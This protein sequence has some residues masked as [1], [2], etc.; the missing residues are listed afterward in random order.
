MNTPPLL[1]AVLPS[2]ASATSTAFSQERTDA[3]VT[4][5]PFLWLEEMEGPGALAWARGENEKTL[6]VLQSDP[7]YRPFYEQALFILQAKDRIADVPS[8]GGGLEQF[9]RDE[10]QVR[11]VWRRTTRE[12]DRSQHPKWETILDVDAL[13]AAENRNWVFQ[14]HS[15]LPP[16]GRRC[17][18]SLS[19]GGKDAVSI[20]E[21]DR[22]AK[23]FVADGFH[24][25]EGKQDVSWV[26]GDTL[27]VAR[28]WGEGTLTQAGYAFVVK[29]LKRAQPLSEAREIFRGEPT[30]VGASPFVLRDSEGHIH[31]T[32]AARAISSFESEYV[33]FRPDGPV[34]LNLPKKAEIATLA[35][36]R[37]LVK[38]DEDWT[39]SEGI[40]FTAGSMISYDLD[41]WKQD[42]LHA[43][44]SLVFQPGPRQALSEFTH[45]RNFLILT[46][47]EN[48]QS[49][50]FL[51][52]YDQGAWSATPIPL[53]EDTNV[54]L[55][56][57][58]DEADRVIFTVS[59]YLRPTSVWSFDAER[60]SL[61]ELKK[62]P[63]AFDAS[64]HVVEQL[65]AISRDGTS[66]PYF[67]VRPKNAR[68]DGTIP[69]L[70]HGYGGFQESQL[71]SDLGS[72][73]RIWL[74]Q[75][76]AYVVANLRGGGEFGPQWHQA[77][78]AATKQTTWDDFIAVAEDLIRRK[79][80]S[81]RRLG[82]I[83][84][85]QGG[86]LV[87]AAVTQRPELFNAAI[88]EVPLFDMLRYTKLGAGASWIGEYG[89]PAIAEQRAWIEG[90]SPYQKLVA[91]KTYPAPLILTSTKDDRTHPAHGRKAAA[92][93]AALGQ[94]YFYYENIDGGHSAAANLMEDA[95]QLALEYTYASRR[96][97]SE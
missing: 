17:L 39:P 51:Y 26:D 66:V 13:A 5:D 93:L 34:K 35:C 83:G 24:L 60:K 91:G 64:N 27:L 94:P 48:G 25:P 7:R 95:R 18:I 16:E 43:R 50:A 54:S 71:P 19:D 70:L 56:A 40:R 11:G 61:E 14:G 82:A 67:L 74:E 33:V 77:A 46:I 89:D 28:D 2:I 92:K 58:Y 9:W 29:E 22:A 31:A 1:S 73:G 79:I 85:S 38:L 59:S 97:C 47:L 44:P 78:Q 52:K 63:S 49:K 30:D 12:S 20:R 68:F 8:E 53:P 81:P 87:G 21:F 36:G 88:I 37:L 10:N 84:G 55:S 86:L 65:E 57:T 72:M 41:E 90:Y 75:G 80:T 62:A 42:P 23:T 76:N 69:T 4:D 45:T 96:L 6:G 3:A 32:G 15:C